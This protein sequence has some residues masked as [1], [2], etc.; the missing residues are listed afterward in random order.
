M[1][2][3]RILSL[4]LLDLGLSVAGSSILR[5]QNAADTLQQQIGLR[6]AVPP[7]EAATTASSADLGDIEPVQRYP[8]PAMLTF[9]TLQE[10]FHT[11]N[12]FY[13]H[14]G[15]LASSAYL[16]GYSGSYVPY[17]LRDWTPRVTLQ[18]NMV[19]YDAVTAGN[20][21]NEN[22]LFSSQYVFGGDR[23]WTWTAAV[24]LARF[25]Q[26]SS[27]TDHEFYKEVVYDNQVAHTNKLMDNV[28][29]FLIT[30]FDVAYHQTTPDTYT[31]I[32]NTL[33]VNL[34]WTPVSEVSLSLYARPSYRIY[35]NDTPD[36]NE[37]S[38]QDTTGT[39]YPAT[40]VGGQHDR[41]DF[42]IMSGFDVTYTP[43]K[44]FSVSADFN[45]AE[46]YS[47]NSGLSYD[48]MSPGI[49]LTGT[50]KF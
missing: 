35:F 38:F 34:T 31:R 41:A 24:N 21:D 11:D 9:S 20:F 40:H 8:K 50:Y 6:T 23:A 29:L 25:T 30:A 10:Y 14:R 46:D 27:S 48:Q 1:K 3:R 43:I 16:G 17:S 45:T 4:A 47:N 39:I 18:Y 13:T 7:P 26:A 15:D 42:N 19:R 28:P 12:V 44:Y 2:L 33:S 32:D 49:S 22:G 5:A 36:M 37:S